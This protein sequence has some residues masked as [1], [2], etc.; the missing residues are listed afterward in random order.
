[1]ARYLRSMSQSVEW[2]VEAI[3]N[4][5]ASGPD[6]GGPSIHPAMAVLA[7]HSVLTRWR[8]NV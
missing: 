7:A 6:D 2:G 1:M 3:D 4:S 8:V 5:S